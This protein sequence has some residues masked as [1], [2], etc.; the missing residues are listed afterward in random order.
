MKYCA[1]PLETLPEESS[2]DD[3]AASLEASGSPT[4]TT[5]T[6]DNDHDHDHDHDNDN[7]NDNYN[8]NKMPPVWRRDGSRD[9]LQGVRQLLVNTFTVQTNYMI[10]R[11]S[12]GLSQK[13]SHGLGRKSS[14]EISEEV[15]GK[16]L[17]TV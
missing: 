12:Q 17:V 16:P 4:T 9:D 11:S 13:S 3:L 2:K 5:T 10:N 7:D 8:D 14:F 15:V 6:T 1:R